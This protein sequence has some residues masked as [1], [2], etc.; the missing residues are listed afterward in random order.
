MI[1]QWKNSNN[2]TLEILFPLLS[3][4][5]RIVS[6]NNEITNTQKIQGGI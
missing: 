4:K 5:W 1:R 6:T 2:L 3:E